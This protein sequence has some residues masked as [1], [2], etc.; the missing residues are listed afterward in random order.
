MIFFII[1][2]NCRNL[3]DLIYG[4]LKL[5]NSYRFLLIVFFT[6]V[7]LADFLKCLLARDHKLIYICL[8]LAWEDVLFIFMNCK[9][10]LSGD[11]ETLI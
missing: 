3:N 9:Q 4:C 8:L 5:V 2:F 11:F 7:N 6:Y 10:S 1:M